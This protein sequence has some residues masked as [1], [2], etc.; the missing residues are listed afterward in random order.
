MSNT[1]AGG[2][3]V[4]AASRGSMTVYWAVATLEAEAVA[5]VQQVLPPGWIATL[6]DR[7]LTPDQVAALR[8]RRGGVRQLKAAP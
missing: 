3:Y 2:I 6:T 4:V 5:T 1:I 7:R 8:L